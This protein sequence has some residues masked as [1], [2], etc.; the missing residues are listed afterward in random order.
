MNEV[1]SLLETKQ[2]ISQKGGM[3]RCFLS[4]TLGK[5]YLH[6]IKGVTWVCTISCKIMVITMIA[7]VSFTKSKIYWISFATYKLRHG[8]VPKTWI[9]FMEMFFV[10]VIK[11][12]TRT[13]NVVRNAGCA[14]SRYTLKLSQIFL[15]SINELINQST[16]YI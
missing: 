13:T 3:L 5:I 12:S 11:N 16:E 4:P 2:K 15:K 8:W 1:K 14:R 6:I 7:S 9:N 10:K